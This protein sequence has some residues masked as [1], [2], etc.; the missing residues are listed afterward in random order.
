MKTEILEQNQVS[1]AAKLL[2]D[3]E[4]ICFPTE[5][6]Y[7]IGVVCDNEQSYEELI[8]VKGRSPDKPIS[9]MA[10]DFK[11][12][13]PYLDI[14]EKVKSICEQFYPGEVTFLLKGKE[15]IP[16]W[17]DLKTGVVGLRVPASDFVNS[18]LQKVGKPCL[19]TSAN[20]SGQKTSTKFDET[21][22]VFNGLVPGI[23]K[24]E[25]T[26]NVASTIVDLTKDTP[27]LIRQ[28]KLEFAKILKA[29]E[30]R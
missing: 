13:L 16:S 19:V 9:L 17:I 6:V 23:V 30:E 22:N 14:D 8:K 26:S 1:E 11:D 18:L 25:C 5:T 21:Y 20:M 4:V 28:G 10:A 29:W 12:A 15:N 2:R 3:G 24:G 7:G 27:V